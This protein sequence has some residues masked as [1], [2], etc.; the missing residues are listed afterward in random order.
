MANLL[1]SS[2]KYMV[3]DALLP[4]KKILCM[5]DTNQIYLFNNN[6][7]LVCFSVESMTIG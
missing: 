5:F 4:I 1:L 7:L 6:L 2:A 3:A